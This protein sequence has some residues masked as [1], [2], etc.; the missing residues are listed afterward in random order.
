MLRRGIYI[1]EGGR[2]SSDVKRWVGYLIGW[3][4]VI[5]GWL[6]PIC[7]VCMCVCIKTLHEWMMLIGAMRYN[8]K[9]LNFKLIRLCLVKIADS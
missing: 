1:T 9:M 6:R 2:E 7:Y 5:H 4:I 8:C 3:V